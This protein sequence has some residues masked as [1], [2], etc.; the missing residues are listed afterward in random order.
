MQQTLPHLI[1]AVNTLGNGGIKVISGDDN[2][3]RKAK[4]SLR[5][6]NNP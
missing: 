4:G 1:N 3:S 6:Q 2:G 5:W